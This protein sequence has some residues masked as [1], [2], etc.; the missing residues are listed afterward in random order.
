MPV[1]Q[2]PAPPAP[3][4]NLPGLQENKN[5]ACLSESEHKPARPSMIEAARGLKEEAA[6]HG[7]VSLRGGACRR[8]GAIA[9]RMRDRMLLMDRALPCILEHAFARAV[10]LPWPKVSMVPKSLCFG[11]TVLHRRS[12]S[13][14]NKGTNAKHKFVWHSQG[15]VL[16]LFEV[17]EAIPGRVPGPA[18]A[19]AVLGDPAFA[20]ITSAVVI[21]SPV[22]PHV[23][24]K[25][26]W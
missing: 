21:R 17:M 8:N 24:N 15:V 20:G 9:L 23:V 3:K 7:F 5:I 26:T 10:A 25:L 16:I 14:R 22:M 11:C 6:L 1:H 13:C 2:I 18:F 12:T 4:M 19:G